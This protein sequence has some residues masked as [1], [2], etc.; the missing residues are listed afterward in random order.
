M[1]SVTIKNVRKAYGEAQVIHGVSLD[2]EDGAF[3]VL[4]GPSGCGKST[5][6]A[7][8]RGLNPSP[9]AKS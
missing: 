4:L 5:C 8:S 2:I 7:W 3:V 9:A 6:C 1:A